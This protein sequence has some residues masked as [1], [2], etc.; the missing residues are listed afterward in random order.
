VSGHINKCDTW[1]TQ[2]WGG[3]FITP[4]YYGVW[5]AKLANCFGLTVLLREV[6]YDALLTSFSIKSYLHFLVKCP[7]NVFAPIAVTTPFRSAAKAS[8]EFRGLITKKS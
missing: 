5:L 3:V 2:E 6:Q 7:L 1:S 4:V 8:S